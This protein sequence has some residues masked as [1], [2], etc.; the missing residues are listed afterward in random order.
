VKNE[1]QEER[2]ARLK[3]QCMRSLLDSA[4]LLQM[5]RAA[6]VSVACRDLRAPNEAFAEACVEM[7]TELLI[8]VA[9][10]MDR[11]KE[12]YEYGKTH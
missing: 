12:T 2:L 10:S 4:A 7:A 11:A 1:T 6:A 5:N 3:Q 9:A 8:Y